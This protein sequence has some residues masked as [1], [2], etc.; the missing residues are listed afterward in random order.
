[1]RI[2]EVHAPPQSL[3]AGQSRSARTP[4]TATPLELPAPETPTTD[5]PS[6]GDRPHGPQ[7]AAEHSHRSDV[8][9]LR[10]WIN[11]P[12]ARA[13]LA[14]PDL[15]AEHKGNGFQKAVAAYQAMMASSN[16]TPPTD[17]APVV[18]EPAPVVTE[19]A[20]VVTEP[21]P[22]VTEPA[23]VVTD[24]SVTEPP[25]AVIDPPAAGTEAV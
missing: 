17:P 1:M 14:L 18:T 7:A 25:A 20:P 23:P 9:A 8:A 4:K 2:S 22:V 15:A 16:P 5:A 13:D 10:Q 12:E 6:E 19:P 24:P 11:H 21:A 3:T